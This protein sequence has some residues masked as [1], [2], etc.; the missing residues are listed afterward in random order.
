MM[1]QININALRRA[2]EEEIRTANA[3]RRCA[4]RTEDIMRTLR[5][6]RQTT[7]LVAMAL[8][9][10]GVQ[11]SRTGSAL[12]TYGETGTQ[13][14]RA[15]EETERKIRTWRTVSSYTGVITQRF[16]LSDLYPRVLKYGRIRF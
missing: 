3:V 16:Y 13:I 4:A 8:E 6:D 10:A 11:L 12:R 5:H 2:S 7:A 14:C 9:K 15:Y 1:T